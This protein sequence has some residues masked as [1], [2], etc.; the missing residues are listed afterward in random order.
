MSPQRRISLAFG[1]LYLITFITSI[2]ALILFQP[3]STIPRATSPE[4]APTPAS[5]SGRSW[6]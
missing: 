4:P 5:I 2:L 3:V 1:A 6:S